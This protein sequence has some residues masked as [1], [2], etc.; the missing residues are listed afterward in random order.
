MA[1]SYGLLNI[2]GEKNH[3]VLM[4]QN[5]GSYLKRQADAAREAAELEARARGGPAAGG[6][7]PP[8]S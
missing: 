5:L 7:P 3:E 1:L 6:P 2:G 8:G 4:K